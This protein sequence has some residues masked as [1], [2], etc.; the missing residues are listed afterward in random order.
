MIT[1]MRIESGIHRGLDTYNCQYLNLRFSPSY[2]LRVSVITYEYLNKRH[3]GI[4]WC[5][6]K[7][8]LVGEITSTILSV[9]QGAESIF[10]SRFSAWFLP[11][12]KLSNRF[13]LCRRIYILVVFLWHVIRFLNTW[14]RM[15]RVASLR[16]FWAS[17]MPY[18]H[19]YRQI[20][21]FHEKK[22]KKHL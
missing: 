1:A 11:R 4:F 2:I 15:K 12:G 10:I 20:S 14:H 7:N 5:D 9:F 16:M 8:S 17:Q 22:W 19:L 18:R 13:R 6:V 21:T 3:K